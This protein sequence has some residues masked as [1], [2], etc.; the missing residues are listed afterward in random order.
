MKAI[1][2]IDVEPDLHTGRFDGV[3][4]GL[5]ELLKILEYY[6]IKA[7]FF[8]TGSVL[9]KYPSLFKKINKS[10]HEVAIHGYSHKRFDLMTNNE[11]RDEL[12]RCIKIYHKVLKK[13]PIGFRAPQHSID[14]DTLKILIKEG[15]KYDAS[16]TPGN[17]MLLRHLFKRKSNKKEILKNFFSNFKPYHISKNLYEIPR[18]SF[19]FSTGGFELKIYPRLLYRLSILLHRI[20]KIPLMFVIH[21]WD[22]IDVKDSRTSKLCSSKEFED[23]L[24]NFLEYSSLRLQYVSV[25][26]LLN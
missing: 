18:P 14:E 23:K 22:L 19:L 8:V 15:F 6:K 1:F 17:L 12:E 26:S 13:Y 11:K 21:S 7:T 5:P 9:E 4:K 2:S 16:K 24:N 3:K 25:K 10:G 20:F